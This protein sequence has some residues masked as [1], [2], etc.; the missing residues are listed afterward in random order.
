MK[1]DTALISSVITE[2]Q[3]VLQLVADKL[4]TSDTLVA[5]EVFTAFAAVMVAIERLD[6][7]HEHLHPM[8]ATVVAQAAEAL[9]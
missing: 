7:V 6:L 1:T 2:A 4:Q 3:A 5:D 9:Q 8:T